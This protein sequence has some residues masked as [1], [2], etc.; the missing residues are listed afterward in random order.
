M[1]PSHFEIKHFRDKS[2]SLGF[3]L[4]MFQ[5]GILSLDLFCKN[6][7]FLEN[8]WK[9]HGAERIFFLCRPKYIGSQDLQLGSHI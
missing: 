4:T 1:V 6:I 5:S 2:A 9:V 8:T 7:F 3:G